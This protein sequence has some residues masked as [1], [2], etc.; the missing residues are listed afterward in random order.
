MSQPNNPTNRK[1]LFSSKHFLIVLTKLGVLSINFS[2]Y[3]DQSSKMS[4]Y[5]F[6]YFHN[7]FIYDHR[8]R[9]CTINIRVLW[10]IRYVWNV[11]WTFVCIENKFVR[12]DCSTH[13]VGESVANAC[14]WLDAIRIDTEALSRW[15]A[16]VISKNDVT[17][18]TSE[19]TQEGMLRI[20][21]TFVDRV[22][23]EIKHTHTRVQTY[24]R[25]NHVSHV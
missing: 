22:H 9:N 7:L 6:F 18:I 21:T 25:S 1:Q 10:K 19:H 3:F 5:S 15:R 14:C 20:Y 8:N 16:K 11:N 4:L 12:A 24:A 23:I 13:W 17:K 2:L